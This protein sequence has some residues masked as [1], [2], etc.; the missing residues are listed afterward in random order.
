[1][2]LQKQKEANVLF[3]EQQKKFGPIINALTKC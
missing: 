3:E 2:I 1:M